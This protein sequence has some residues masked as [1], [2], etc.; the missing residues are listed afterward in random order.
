MTRDWP[1]GKQALQKASALDR[2]RRRP[3]KKN[4][5]V[6]LN[7]LLAETRDVRSITSENV[8]RTGTAFGVDWEKDLRVERE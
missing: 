4:A 3:P 2:L 1:F 5:L 7:N 6:V 8:G